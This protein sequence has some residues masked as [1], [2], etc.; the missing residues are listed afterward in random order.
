MRLVVFDL[1]GV[2]VDSKDIHF[3]ALNSAL[4]S[5]RPGSSIEK[6][7]HLARFDGLD[8]RSKLRK[9]IESGCISPEELE[10]V[11][12]LKQR[13]TAS[14]F[15]DLPVDDELVSIFRELKSR[16][17][18]LAV[19]SNSIRTTVTTAIGALGLGEFVDFYLGNEDVTS[20][21]PHP[22]V[23]WRTMMHF[24]TVPEETLIVEDSPVGRESARRSG[25]RTLEVSNRSQLTL[26]LLLEMLEEKKMQVRTP[27]QIQS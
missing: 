4:E 23:Y 16:D 7:E 14:A 27:G 10:D 19:A 3:V 13:F 21:K 24:R 6:S 15:E 11:W 17:L 20:P 5:I 25:A 22:E 8:T 26:G 1:D 9:L 2:L 12:A 18:L